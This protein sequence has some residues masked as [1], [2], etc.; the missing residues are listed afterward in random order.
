MVVAG[1][2]IIQNVVVHHQAIHLFRLLSGILTP[3]VLISLQQNKIFIT[4]KP[5]FLLV[6]ILYGL[7]QK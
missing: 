3:I 1:N 4:M 7:Y 6:S 2:A 5:A